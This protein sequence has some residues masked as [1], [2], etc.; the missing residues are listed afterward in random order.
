MTVRVS[1]SVGSTQ[2]FTA[3]IFPVPVRGARRPSS[4]A[5]PAVWVY[6]SVM[7]QGPE[8]LISALRTGSNAAAAY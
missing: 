8:N 3:Q 5:T 1:G 6:P 7:G 2:S 4:P